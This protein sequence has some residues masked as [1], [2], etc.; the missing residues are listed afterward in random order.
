MIPE[1]VLRTSKLKGDQGLLNAIVARGTPFT[2]EYAVTLSVAEYGPTVSVQEFPG[3]KGRRL[4]WPKLALADARANMIRSE[5]FL[6]STL[7]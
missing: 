6:G 4:L 2:T 5:V 3:A 7:Y 1:V